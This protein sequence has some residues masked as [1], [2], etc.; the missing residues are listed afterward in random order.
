MGS[1]TTP[2]RI[3]NV[4][5]DVGIGGYW[6]HD[7]AAVQGSGARPDGFFF[8][9][10]PSS[11]AFPAVRSPSI[12]YLISL[13][14]DDGQVA[15]GDCV[16]VANAGHAGRPNPLREHDAGKTGKAL[17]A[18]LKGRQF[19]GFRPAA[20]VLEALD[21][22]PE[23]VLPVQFGASQ[24]LLGAAALARKAPMRDVLLDEF[25]LE[26]P[27]TLPGFAGS[28]GGDWEA[29][30]DKAIVRHV[31]MFPQ[32]AIQTAAECERLPEYASWI[33]RRIEKWGGAGYLPDLHFDFHSSLG[34]LL[35]NDEDKVIDYLAGI[36]ART[37]TLQ[38][39]F[40][41]P[42]HARGSEEALARMRSLR[43]K[44]SSRV[45]NCR[46]IADEWAN[47][48]GKVAQFAQARAAHAIQIKMP[49]NGSLLTT[50]E[51]VQAC[52]QNDVL[53]YL[54]GSC[55]E[56]DISAR[57]TVHVGLAFGAWRLFTK[58]GMG[59]DEGLM[60]LKNEMSRTVGRDAPAT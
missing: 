29:N 10:E 8:D 17:A 46:L 1:K 51:A 25:D 33:M 30:V 13:E 32:S 39:Y 56:T 11:S 55:N 47:G 4:R 23:L 35:N 5:V 18:A 14:L 48:P 9:G 20:A 27:R 43:E 59:F 60:V 21:L 15:Y 3:A 54:G 53:A 58:P 40:E 2:F 34:R 28:C 36:C 44:L 16:T 37:P 45:E 57:A 12:A 7:Q 50:I 19:D 52:K 38:V 42:M 22:P 41:D 26:K 49:D 6:I 31:D 24:A